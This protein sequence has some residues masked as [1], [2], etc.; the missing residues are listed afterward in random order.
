MARCAF[1]GYD[2]RALPCRQA[3]GLRTAGVPLLAWT[4]RTS[5]ERARAA[6][7]ADNIIFEAFA[8]H[9]EA[10]AP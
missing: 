10:F 7:F 1:V 6:A 3:L 9:L 4:V 5:A 8:P 2:V